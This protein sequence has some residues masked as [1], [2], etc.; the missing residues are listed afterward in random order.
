V[1]KCELDGIGLRVGFFDA[2]AEQTLLSKTLDRS[3][4]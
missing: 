2:N 4:G 1:L 3:T